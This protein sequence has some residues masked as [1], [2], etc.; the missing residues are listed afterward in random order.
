MVVCTD[1]LYTPL[2]AVPKKVSMQSCRTLLLVAAK[3]KAPASKAKA[4]RH[5]QSK[6]VDRHRSRV[7][8]SVVCSFRRYPSKPDWV[9]FD[10]DH[11][12]ELFEA[13]LVE[14]KQQREREREAAGAG[15]PLE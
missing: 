7:G 15:V 9:V 12:S 2:S 8:G 6:D 4:N 5:S 14:G 13:V 10:D 11:P 1:G 3:S